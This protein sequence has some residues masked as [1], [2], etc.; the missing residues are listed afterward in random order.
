M[1]QAKFPASIWDGSSATR[2]QALD[3]EGPL[4]VHRPP[5]PSD[6]SQA[7]AEIIAVEEALQTTTLIAGAGNTGVLAADATTGFKLIPVINGAPTGI[8]ANVPT[9]YVAL[10]YN[11]T[12]KTLCVYDGGWVASAAMA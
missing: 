8:P 4:V 10:G 5:D 12:A 3:K 7:V 1:S 6:W 11:K 9:G 2:T